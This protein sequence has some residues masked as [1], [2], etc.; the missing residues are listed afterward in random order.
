MRIEGV[1]VEIIRDS[2]GADT[3]QAWMNGDGFDVQ[4]SVPSGKSTGAHEAHALE[5]SRAL[6]KFGAVQRELCARDFSSQ[7]EFDDFL[8]AADGTKDKNNLGAN[9]TLALSL[10]FARAKAREEKKELFDYIR[11]IVSARGSTPFP[12]P[13]FNMINGGAHVKVPNDWK[14]AAGRNLKLDFQEFQII[15]DTDD[16]AIALA[17]AQQFYMKLE[18]Y[19]HKHYGQRVLTG[20]EAGFFCPFASNGDALAALGDVIDAYRYPLRIGLDVA[21]TQFYRNGSYTVDGASYDA[22][23]LHARYL[24]LM[25][26]YGIV[27]IEDPFYEEDFESFAHLVA[28][29]GRNRL[30]IT[31]DLTATN[32][33]RLATALEKEAGNAILIKPNQIGTLSETL[34]VCDMAHRAGWKTIVSHRSGETEDDFIADL[35]FG[36]GAWGLK[37]GAPATLWRMNKYQR[38]FEIW[39]KVSRK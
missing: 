25:S 37:S 19:L 8:I 20:D 38:L 6:G 15:P 28:D 9:L 35:A 2:R 1:R 32:P 12:H 14:D 16:Y 23:G 10:A 17:M 29:A 33:G 18:E 39:E 26:A 30:V 5:P 4:A 7:K 36:V 3:L 22:V 34:T 24:D 13:V 27:S 11:G 21:A 31:D